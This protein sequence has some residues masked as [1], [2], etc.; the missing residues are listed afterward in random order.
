MQARRSTVLSIRQQLKVTRHHISG[1]RCGANTLGHANKPAQNDV[2]R[3]LSRTIL[4]DALLQKV[5]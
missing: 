5:A 2:V 3:F 4:P 1:A